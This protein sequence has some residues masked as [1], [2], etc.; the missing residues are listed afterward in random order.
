MFDPMTSRYFWTP[1]PMLASLLLLPPAAALR[2]PFAP[3]VPRPQAAG[4]RHLPP[5]LLA[6]E[7]ECRVLDE[8]AVAQPGLGSRFGKAWEGLGEDVDWVR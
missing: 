4:G 2:A 3:P 7:E 1:S 8:P 6:S 5:L